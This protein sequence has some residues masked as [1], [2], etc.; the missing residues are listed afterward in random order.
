[1]RLFRDVRPRE[2]HAETPV[3]ARSTASG[4]CRIGRAP[5]RGGQARA[6]QAAGGGAAGAL[7][8]TGVSILDAL[9]RA[10]HVAECGDPRGLDIAMLDG[11]AYGLVLGPYVFRKRRLASLV[12][13]GDADGVA[14]CTRQ[15][16]QQLGVMRVAGGARDGQMKG[17]V[18]FHAVAARAYRVVDID[19]GA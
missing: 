7:P 11:P 3:P 18:F 12:A 13:A 17:Q 19:Q 2:Q 15:H 6:G 5:Y 10:L 8:V 14:Q 1:T 4:V 9:S 16:A